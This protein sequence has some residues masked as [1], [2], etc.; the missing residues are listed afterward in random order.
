MVH[1]DR[2]SVNASYVMSI[3]FLNVC[4]LIGDFYSQ[5]MISLFDS[6]S[7]FGDI[8]I[9][10]NKELVFLLLLLCLKLPI[11]LRYLKKKT[12]YVV[13]VDIYNILKFHSKIRRHDSTAIIKNC[14]ILLFII[15]GQLKCLYCNLHVCLSPENNVFY[16][17]NFSFTN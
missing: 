6:P 14:H 3:L 17:T 12:F 10:P 1:V 5:F 15:R 9:Q 16:E 8:V 4:N 11:P 2:N 13:A 7:K